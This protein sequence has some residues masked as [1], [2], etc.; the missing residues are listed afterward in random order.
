MSEPLEK[1]PV[2]RLP[3]SRPEIAL[4]AIAFL[5]LLFIIWMLAAYWLDLPKM[6]PRHFNAL[7]QADVW[8]CKGSLLTL[9]AI[10]FALYI[11]LSLLSQYPHVY[12]YPF[13]LTSE[14]AERQYRYAR[15]LIGALKTE[16]VWIFAYINWRTVQISMGHASDLGRAFL[17]LILIVTTGTIA[18]YFWRAYRAR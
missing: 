11:G 1:R 9:P 17:P 4:E 8:S 13:G 12:N 7:G 5:G 15:L 18:I 14:N 6:V 16:C 10:C 3:R 2:L